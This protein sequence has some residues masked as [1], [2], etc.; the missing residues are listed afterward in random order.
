ML[1]RGALMLIL[2]LGA[3][4]GGREQTSPRVRCDPNKDNECD[5]RIGNVSYDLLES[6]GEGQ[7]QPNIESA[8][9]DVDGAMSHKTD[10]PNECCTICGGP[11]GE[12]GFTPC[13]PGVT[14]C[15]PGF[16]CKMG[17]TIGCGIYDPSTACWP[18]DSGHCFGCPGLTCWTPEQLTVEGTCP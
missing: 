18:I 3:C 6:A 12:C 16:R 1:Y 5:R 4:Y 9:T 2:L 14:K 15:V 7:S 13:I 11:C 8:K 10:T 17:A